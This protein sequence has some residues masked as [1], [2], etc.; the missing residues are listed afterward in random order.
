MKV[1][2][3]LEMHSE[4]IGQIEASG[5]TELLGKA[6]AIEKNRQDTKIASIL[7]YIPAIFDDSKEG[8]EKISKIVKNLREFSRIDE[9]ATLD[10]YN[11]NDGIETALVVVRNQIQSDADIRK[12]LSEVPLIICNPGKINQVLLNILVNAAQAIE[13]QERDDKGTITI[14][15]YQTDDEVVCEISDDGCGISSETVSKIYEPFF[16][17][18]PVGQGTGLGLSVSYDIIVIQHK[19]KLIVDSTVGKGTKFTIKLPINNQEMKKMKKTTVLFVDDEEKILNS[20][21]MGLMDQPYR[22]F[23]AKSG[24]E[25][26]EIL[27]REEVQVIVTDM[28]MPEMSGLELLRTV[29]E[30]YPNIIRMVLSA[31]TQVTTLLTAINQ[32][33]IYKYI[34]KPWKLEEEFKPAIRQAIDYYNIQSE[35]DSLVAES[36]QL[37]K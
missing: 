33:E 4:L 28:R 2:N 26:L 23:F 29:K 25:A 20:L 8:L 17:T 9:L 27:K 34:T 19:G 36:E 10:K 22:K 35:R 12:E 3:Q 18:K 24:K 21:K 13:A 5:E 30:E 1:R 6:K 11:I 32:G 16:T 15:T 7:E 37:K 14:K 31:Y